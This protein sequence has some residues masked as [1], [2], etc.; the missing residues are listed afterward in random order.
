MPS[1]VS[2]G[3]VWVPAKEKT[4]NIHTGEIYDGPDREAK[5][6]IAKETAGAGE[7]IGMKASEDPQVLEVAR[8]HGLTVEQWMERHKPTVQ[9]VEAQKVAASKVVTHQPEPKKAPVQ[10]T[11]GGFFDEQSDAVKEFNKK[12]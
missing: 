3:G 10:N 4:V 7:S 11:K 9:Q 8:Q 2:N 6:F 12:S 5:E 1:F